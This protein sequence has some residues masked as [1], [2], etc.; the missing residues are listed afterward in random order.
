[1]LAFTLAAS[2]AWWALHL[3]PNP[4][5]AAA[6]APASL[7]AAARVAVAEWRLSDA[8]RLLA[9]PAA[10]G[11]APNERAL[12]QAGLD[13]A[14]SRFGAVIERLEPLV[15]AAPDLFEARVLLGRAL[16]AQG[17]G[18]RALAALD[19]MADAYNADRVTG[20]RDLAW[21]GV[22]LSLTGYVK[23]ANRVFKE[24][25]DL[26]ATLDE[27]R[28]L[29][30]DL[31]LE[32][33]NFRDADALYAEVLARRPGDIAATLGRAR[34][35]LRSER[36]VAAARDRLEALLATRPECVPAHTL[37]AALDLEHERPTAA[38]ARLEGQSL[39]LAPQDPEA[40]ALLGAATTLADDAKA[41]AAVERRALAAN[42]RFAAL[43]GPPAEHAAR[44][45]RYDEA[46]ALHRRALALDPEHWPALAGLGIGLSRVGDDEGAIK[47]LNAAFDA[48]PY[49]VRTYNLL[50][51][52][53]DDVAKHYL[54]LE[55]AEARPVRLRVHQREREVLGRYVPPLL[56]EA[57]AALTKKYGFAPKPPLHVEI[58][59]DPQTFSVRS[60]GLP[61]L[62]AHGICFGHVVTSRSPSAGNFNWAEV[63]WH[64]LSHVYHI[65]LSKSRVPRWFTEG[66]AVFESTE[67]RPAW[68]R[69]MDGDLLRAYE[70]GRLRGVVDFNLAF[71]QARSLQDILVAYYHAFKVA[72]FI[73]AT[74][75]FGKMR[76]MLVAWGEQKTTPAV[77]EAALGVTPEAFD[78]RFF[79]WLEG[80]LARLSR[81]FR[82][83][84][85]AA[86]TQAEAL[87]AAAA[88]A[89]TDPDKR[90]AAALAA[91][92]KRDL[93]RALE[94]AEAALAAAP[95]EP[96]A[97]YV[98]AVVRTQRKD[99]A[100][101]AADLRALVAGG[102]DSVELRTRL[103]RLADAAGDPAAA[104][105][106]LLA[107]AA[108]DPKDATLYAPLIAKLD[109]AGRAA[110]AFRWRAR[111]ATVDQ[112]D[113]A[114]IRRLLD[115]GP[116]QG[117]TPAELRAWGEQGLHIAPFSAEL[118]LSFARALVTL[119]DTR[120]AKAEAAIALQL[121]PKLEAARALSEAP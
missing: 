53:Y 42:P 82:P 106:D 21:L 93:D 39:R 56:S 80:D 108:L 95:A 84:P 61:Q 19:P 69:E 20:A 55:P 36:D 48:D 83:Q 114:L 102:H 43:Y 67:A 96:R 31:F 34:V 99:S 118:H 68:E 29:W 112:A 105:T 72:K 73:D 14:R 26:D 78:Q 79:A 66:L 115:D 63:L 11:E 109:A 15:A 92:G 24:A 8:E 45:H 65:Q 54:W 33:Y 121:D 71:T 10:P 12:V 107:A 111:L 41:F 23:N 7:A 38:I 13:L 64:E 57:Y 3:A 74:W 62:S 113:A 85:E 58:F 47:A 1:M 119:G 9:A 81:Q 77:L 98:R 70:A 16:L 44:V 2:A 32:K 116:A 18:D 100:G 37:M 50:A 97:L 110:E 76:R 22:G 90:A 49:D 75:G 86:A 46:L 51:H 59:P 103:A 104:V 101:A 40:L 25:L 30:G 35:D 89:P 27:A 117:A 17:R 28:V 52:F 6:P 88:A 91:L 60:T 4:A 87:T 5:G 94:H 120:R